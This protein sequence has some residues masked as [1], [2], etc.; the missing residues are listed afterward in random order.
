VI[1]GKAEEISEHSNQSVN[2]LT[3]IKRRLPS[4]V[5]FDPPDQ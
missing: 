1:G 2:P 5:S 3:M 4:L